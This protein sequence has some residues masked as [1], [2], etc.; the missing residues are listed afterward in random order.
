[1]PRDAIVQIYGDSLRAV[2]DDLVDAD[3][4]RS[5]VV[6]TRHLHLHGER[7]RRLIVADL[8]PDPVDVVSAE[9]R[10][11]LQL[12]VL[13]LP[14]IPTGPLLDI[15]CGRSGALIR[16]LRAHGVVAAGLDRH[17]PLDSGHRADWLDADYGHAC[18]ATITSHLSFSLHF[19]HHHHAAHAVAERYAH[20]YMRIL[21]SLSSDGMFTYVPS[22]PPIEG[23]LDP[24][25][26]HVRRAPI[27]GTGITRTTIVRRRVAGPS[28]S[29]RTTR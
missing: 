7:F 10:P 27:A 21:H 18:W 19:L 8:G 29:R 13:G 4:H 15:G 22:L 28:S 24:N 20:A 12:E 6:L 2:A 14:A 5:Q 26:W 17:A 25:R 11:E 1:M 9:Y 16:H 23:I 3:G